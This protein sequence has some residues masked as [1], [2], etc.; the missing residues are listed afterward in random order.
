MMEKFES[1]QIIRFERLMAVPPEIPVSGRRL[2]MT[3]GATG[4]S[5]V[6]HGIQS[7]KKKAITQNIY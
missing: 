6:M 7:L 4:S 1:Y 3:T 2:N 5:N